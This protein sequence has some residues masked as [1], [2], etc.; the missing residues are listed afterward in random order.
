MLDT[1]SKFQS[2]IDYTPIIHIYA[3]SI[4]MDSLYIVSKKTLEPKSVK[5]KRH[6]GQL[7]AISTP[8]AR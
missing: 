3:N 7:Q 8:I 6:L 1:S 2:G 5:I 4:K